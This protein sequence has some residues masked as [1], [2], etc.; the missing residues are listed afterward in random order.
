[1]FFLLK[2]SNSYKIAKAQIH[3]SLRKRCWFNSCKK[4]W[5]ND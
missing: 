2:F 5:K 1:L 3:I 4:K